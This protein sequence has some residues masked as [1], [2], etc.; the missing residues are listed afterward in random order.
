MK[1]IGAKPLTDGEA[2]ADKI[3]S[4][5]EA[6]KYAKS[7]SKKPERSLLRAYAR[8]W[9]SLHSLA[10]DMLPEVP[11]DD[12]VPES[13]LDKSLAATVLHEGR[14]Q[15]VPVVPTKVPVAKTVDSDEP[16][17]KSPK[18]SEL[19]SVS[20]IMWLVSCGETFVKN[21]MFGSHSTLIRLLVPPSVAWSCC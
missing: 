5:N 10:A 12:V 9:L 16:R 19:K 11:N 15:I 21:C 18:W 6:Q 2:V 13:N 17:T 7:T 14:G 20:M 3:Q 8:A 4:A 1:V